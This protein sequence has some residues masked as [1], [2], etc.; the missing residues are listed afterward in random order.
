[1][2]FSVRQQNDSQ[3]V[4]M[5]GQFNFSDNQKFKEIIALVDTDANKIILNMESIT[6]VDSAA[7]GMLLV[8]RDEAETKGKKV[9]IHHPKGQVK[10][11]M[12]ISKFD[13]IFE[14]SV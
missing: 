1:M 13:Q 5:Q 14:Y 12:E 7:L 2:E 3:H 8:L 6:F 10:T 4:V 11:V 9:A